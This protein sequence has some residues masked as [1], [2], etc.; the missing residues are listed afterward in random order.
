MM[1]SPLFE[2]LCTAG[3]LASNQ[4]IKSQTYA[5]RAL[6]ERCCTAVHCWPTLLISCCISLTAYPSSMDSMLAAFKHSTAGPGTLTLLRPID[7]HLMRPPPLCTAR[8]V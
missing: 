4:M 6:P 1:Q 3:N 8:S 5:A 2:G 7:S